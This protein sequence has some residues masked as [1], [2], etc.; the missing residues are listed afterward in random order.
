MLYVLLLV[1][2]CYIVCAATIGVATNPNKRYPENAR[3]DEHLWVLVV[4]IGLPLAALLV[5]LGCEK[6]AEYR[7]ETYMPDRSVQQWT[8]REWQKGEAHA[9]HVRRIDAWL[10]TPPILRGEFPERNSP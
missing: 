4:I 2:L 5:C 7:A 10:N 9:D 6:P 3:A 1:A 8:P